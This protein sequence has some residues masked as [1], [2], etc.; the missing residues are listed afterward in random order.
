MVDVSI[1]VCTRNRVH[2][3]GPMLHSIGQ[4]ATFAAARAP[5][6][7]VELVVVDNGSTDGTGEL[8]ERWAASAALPVLL[9]REARPGLARSRNVG[10]GASQ[11][12]IVVF[13][14]DDCRVAEDYV[15]ELLRLDAAA[16]GPTLWGGRVELGDPTDLPFTIKTDTA[17]ATYDGARHPGGFLHG[18]NM[19]LARSTFDAIGPFDERFGA[20]APLASAEDTDYLYRAY[21]AG[22]AVRYVPNLVVHHFHGRK[23]LADIV[24][25]SRIYAV[26]NGA[27]YLKHVRHWNLFRNFVWDVKG[28]VRELR[29]GAPIDRIFG[30][31]Y[32]SNVAGCLIGMW[33]M[34]RLLPGD[35][36][37]RRA[38]RAG[39]KALA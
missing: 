2:S 29:G 14:D 35:A 37:A 18:C 26:G 38:R 33:R 28:S 16:E 15:V 13:T 1:V 20:G 10:V 25:L 12:R 30:V 34:L 31:S 24:R 21:L 9:V 5:A 7:S 17:A 22:V 8:V 11:G 3:L 6:P 39:R 19:A 36:L 27:L 23:D 32:R 4:A